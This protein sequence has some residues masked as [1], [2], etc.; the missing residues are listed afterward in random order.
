MDGGNN[1]WSLNKNHAVKLLLLRLAEHFQSAELRYPSPANYD[2]QAIRIMS[3]ATD[4]SLYVYTYGQPDGCY[5]IDL[6]YP[7]PSESVFTEERFEGLELEKAL[8]VIAAHL[9]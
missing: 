2:D 5:G 3:R 4:M 7:G 9:S 6:E 8:E 1:I